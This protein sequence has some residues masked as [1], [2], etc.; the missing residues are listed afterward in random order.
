MQESIKPE[1]RSRHAVSAAVR[2][3]ANLCLSCSSCLTECPVNKAT[4]RLQPLKLVRMANWGLLDEMVRLPEIWYCLSCNKCRS[5]CPMEVKPAALMAYLRQEAVARGVVT[6]ESLR[7]LKALHVR[8]QRVRLHV[9]SLCLKGESSPDPAAAW[10]RCAN[11]P[12]LDF[13]DGSGDGFRVVSSAE[14]RR[15]RRSL[16]DYLGFPTNLMSCYT[17]RECSNACPAV[18]ETAVFD[19]LQIFRMA[20]FGLFEQLLRSPSIWLCYDCQSCT[21]AC[22]QLVSGHLALRRTRETA[23]AEGFV[24]REFPDRWREAQR[25]VYSYFLD[26]VDALLKDLQERA[27]TARRSAER[28][29]RDLLSRP[30]D[31]LDAGMEPER[32]ERRT[33]PLERKPGE[34]ERMRTAARISRRN[35]FY[36]LRARTPNRNVRRPV[37]TP[38]APREILGMKLSTRSR[39]GVRLM[40]DMAQR[41]EQGP[42]QLGAI[43]KRQDIPVKYLE[44]IIIPLKKAEYVKSVRGYKGGHMLAKAPGDISV[45][46]IVELL[47]GGLRLTRCTG[48]ADICRRSDSC[49]TRSIW[50]EATDAMFEKLNSITFADLAAKAEAGNGDEPGKESGHEDCIDSDEQVQG[51]P[52]GLH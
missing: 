15:L 3:D 51:D 17:C 25:G 34:G 5:V 35:G 32:A 28:E 31:G 52:Q 1:P 38:P 36:G 37:P 4:N 50:K 44:Q 26:Q 33:R 8:L 40:L 27:A 45:G 13:Q 19:P 42:V 48:D 11:A 21:R 23:M 29:V 20:A 2:A 30:A 16:G 41:Y 7:E 14:N 22:T 43:A 47:E 39:Y 46:E 18:H 9:A 6:E 12:V 49:P 10:Q 24:D